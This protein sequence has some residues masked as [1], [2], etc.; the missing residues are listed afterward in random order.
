M[1]LLPKLLLVCAAA[2]TTA[3][4]FQPLYGEQSVAGGPAVSA[5]LAGVDVL[6]IAAPTGTDDARIAVELN[7]DLLFG[8]QGGSGAGSPTHSL[9]ILLTTSRYTTSVDLQTGRSSTDIY[10]LTATYELTDL[11]TGKL[12]LKDRA[13]APVSYDTPGEQQRYARARGLRD[14]ENRATQ[15]VADTIRSR[16]ASFFVAGS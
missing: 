9:K 3:G 6:P 16:L 7:N 14:A 8:L 13:Y 12:V 11:R 15:L 10:A 4:C 1:G 2:G 5:A